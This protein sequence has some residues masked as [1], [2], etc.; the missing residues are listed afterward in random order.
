MRSELRSWW[1]DLAQTARG[2]RELARPRRDEAT[3]DHETLLERTQRLVERLHPPRMRLRLVER[4][5]ET[6]TACT[7]RF[8]RTDGPLPPFRP[9]QYVSLSL[10]IGEVATTRPYSISSA[11]GNA[12]LDLTLKLKPGGFASPYLFAEVRPG[13]EVSASGP[14]GSFVF[15]PLC[16]R[17]ELV[18]FAGG[19]GITPFMSMLRH[20]TRVGFPSRVLLLYGS[21]RADDVLFGAELEQL[22]AAHRALEVVSVISE[23]DEGHRGPTG[24]LGAEVIARYVSDVASKTFLVCGPEGM[25]R[26][27]ESALRSLGVPAHKVR[28]ESFGPPS[29]VTAESDWPP[30]VTAAQEFTIEVE[31]RGSFATHAGETLLSA[32]ERHGVAVPSICRT[33]GCADCRLRLLQGRVYVLPGAGVRESDRAAGIIHSCVSYAISDVRVATD[34]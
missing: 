29:D 19:S 34:R 8:E 13:W 33:G 14:A 21:R 20:F 7:L 10:R 16:D 22:R 24:L 28:R 5:A 6:P 17:G 31:G 26:H 3:D 25:N 4:I 23:P 18:F 9:G 15:E 11:P 27:V 12:Q 32:L 30:T 1:A 2:L